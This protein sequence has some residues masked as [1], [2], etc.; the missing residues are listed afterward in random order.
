METG[1]F[2][3][4]AQNSACRGKLWS[5]TITFSALHLTT[6]TV[7]DIDLSENELQPSTILVHS[8][9]L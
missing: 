5:L 4:S 7:T 2:S 9:L 3:I 1:K 6:W 8:L